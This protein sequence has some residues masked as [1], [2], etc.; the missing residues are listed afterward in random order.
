LRFF[1]FLQKRR[2]ELKATADR[3][4]MEFQATDEY[5]LLNWLKDFDL[6]K[7]GYAK[8]IS[9]ILQHPKDIEK[10]DFRVFDY[11]YIIGAGNSTRKIQQTVFFVHSKSL[12]LPQLF[13]RPE[14]F[15]DRVKKYFGNED[16]NFE[17]FPVFSKDYYL[18]GNNEAMIRQEFND[19][20]LHYFTV[21][22]KWRLEGLNYL[23]IFYG[24][25]K[26]I[27]ADQIDWFYEKGMEVY[28]LFAK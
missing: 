17:A 28:D 4:G 19:E 27:P 12:N 21:N 2:T 16:I 10:P 1:S 23:L 22:K 13:M 8:R 20:V 3:L 26:R 18:K 15:F 7:K 11:R 25:G 24:R 5:G 14:H 9:N 6:F